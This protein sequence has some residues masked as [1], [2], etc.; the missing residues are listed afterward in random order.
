MFDYGE[1]R[2]R[3]DERMRAA[4]VDLLFLAPSSDLEYLTGLERQIPTFGQSS[5][6]ND[7]VSGTFFRPGREPVFLLTRMAAVFEAAG[8][9]PGELVVVNERD[10]GFAVFERVARGLGPAR[11]AAVGDRVW[12]ET[13]LNL[14]RIFGGDGLVT[15]SRLV[16]ELRRR[17]S[18]EELAV[19]ERACEVADE[20][21]AAVAPRVLP[22]VTMCELA[23]EVDH[24]MRIRG[25]RTPSFT[26]RVFT[27]FGDDDLDSESESGTRPL[28]EGQCVMFDYG[29]V[30]DGYC[31]D[32]GRAIFCGEP[33]RE[34]RDVYAVML[35]AQEAGRAATRPGVPASEVNRA[36][37]APIEEA[38]LG[39]HFLHRMGHGIGLDVHERPFLS[40]ED[41]T[42]LET[43][44]TFT[45]EPSIIRPGRAAVR[46]EDVIVCEE[47]GGRKLNRHPPDLVANT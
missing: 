18:A 35:A 33:S 15:G 34:D 39:E 32:F 5:Q 27:G 17:K 29:A 9:V 3:L 12:A 1:R 46:I 38:G 24:Q 14:Q 7:W 37:R 13:V 31:S 16:S 26:T 45:D 19:M 20:T 41:E 43:S 44:M 2:R 4:D 42:P 47:R 30:V 23:E 21:M 6:A 25:S 28:R 40:E 11:L 36:C 10:D 8:D 22:G